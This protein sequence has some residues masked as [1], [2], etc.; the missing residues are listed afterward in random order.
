MNAP[1]K[2]IRENQR[3]RARKDLL[4][5]AARLMKQG[6]TPT[7]EEIA[8]EALISRA[9]AYRYFSN[10]EALLLEASID[11]AVPDAEQ[12]FAASAETDPGIR[13]EMV[14]TALHDMILENHTALRMMLAQSL[15]RG[16]SPDRSADL[17]ARQNRRL[18]L[19]EAALRPAQAA[20]SPAALDRLSK[21]VAL[22]VGP[23]AMVVF[24]DVLRLDDAEARAV[25]RWMIRVLVDAARRPA[26]D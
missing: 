4:Q 2:A 24:Q 17:P 11:I 15:Q 20:F 21:A 7:I 16:V 1:E 13:L 6:R 5:A 22:I 8:S 3:R 10:V 26:L 25:K 12:L 19:I 14:D 18:P 23:E 9:T